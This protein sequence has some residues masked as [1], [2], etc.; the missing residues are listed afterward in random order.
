MHFL[1]RAV[2]TPAFILSHAALIALGW[3]YIVSWVNEVLKQDHLSRFWNTVI[4]DAVVV[5]TA[6]LVA[7]NTLPKGASLTWHQF[8]ATLF[9]T[10]AAALLNHG[11]FLSPTGIGPWLQSL[12]SYKPAPPQRTAPAA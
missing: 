9:F 12:T 8:A 11:G 5:G 4:A 1:I 6:L 2:V 7:L 3:G 10:A